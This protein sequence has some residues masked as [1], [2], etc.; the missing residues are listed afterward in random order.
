MASSSFTPLGKA[1]SHSILMTDKATSGVASLGARTMSSTD[2]AKDS[3]SDTDM[4]EE[5]EDE[6]KKRGMIHLNF[7]VDPPSLSTSHN[8]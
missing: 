6:N 8:R 2:D 4:D 3:K 1:N 5:D 7:A